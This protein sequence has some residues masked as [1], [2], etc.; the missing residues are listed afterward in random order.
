MK[1]AIALVFQDVYI[2]GKF[3]RRGVMIKK[4]P[5][6]KT[7]SWGLP[8]IEITPEI[9]EKGVEVSLREAI[10]GEMFRLILPELPKFVCEIEHKGDQ[11][12][13]YHARYVGR[14]ERNSFN[15][16]ESAIFYDL[17]PYDKTVLAE[18]ILKLLPPK[19]RREPKPR[20]E[21]QAIAF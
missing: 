17:K 18:E 15:P 8:G 12:L 1:I 13:V 9:E 16:A 2:D 20:Y 7:G 19:K 3:E 10:Q 11:Y 14:P 5:G 6:A 4:I 21:I